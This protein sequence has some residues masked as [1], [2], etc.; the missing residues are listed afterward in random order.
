MERIF[1]HYRKLLVSQQYH[2]KPS[3]SKLGTFIEQQQWD[4]AF[5]ELA[6]PLHEGLYEA[7]SF[8]FLDT[9]TP[10][11]RLI[12]SLDYIK[13]QVGQ[14]GF[15]QLFQNCYAPLLVTAI[16]SAQAAFIGPALQKTLDDALKVFV[17]NNE[18]L[19][20]ETDTVGFAALYDEFKEFEPLE[21]QFQQELPSVQR[22]II[23][24]VMADMDIGP[25]NVQGER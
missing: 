9:L 2:Q 7:Q 20:K 12:I 23:I 3:G 1:S 16:E 13:M 17:L 8:D 18:S 4:A 19:A 6:R 15:I 14:G 22:D 24:A 11:D 21:E 10:L 5:Q 25:R